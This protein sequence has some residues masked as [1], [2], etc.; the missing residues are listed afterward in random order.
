VEALSDGLFRAWGSVKHLK[1]VCDSEELR[2]AVQKVQPLIV[3]Y[4]TRVGQSQPI[5]KEWAAITEK[6]KVFGDASKKTADGELDLVGGS[7]SEKL[8]SSGLSVSLRRVV[9]IELRDAKLS[10]V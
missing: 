4:G 7:G 5:Y 1:S 8:N 2:D 6:L 10:G 9:S 3:E